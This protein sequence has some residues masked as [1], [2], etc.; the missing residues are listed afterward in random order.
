MSGV[1]PVQ[2]PVNGGRTAWARSRGTD[3][4]GI[5]EGADELKGAAKEGLSYGAERQEKPE[6]IPND[7]Y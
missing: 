5:E 2:Y 1:N 4:Q 3:L 7:V 6:V